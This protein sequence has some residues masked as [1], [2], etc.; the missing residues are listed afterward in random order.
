MKSLVSTALIFRSKC[1]VSLCGLFLLASTSRAQVTPDPLPSWNDGAAKRAIVAFVKGMTN[2]GGPEFVP[3]A[4]RIATF[5]NDGTRPW[6]I[7]CETGHWKSKRDTS[8]ANGSCE[9]ML[10]FIKPRSWRG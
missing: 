7:S 3:V 5:D 4:R 8:W 9:N 2:E 10:G 1:A 6:F